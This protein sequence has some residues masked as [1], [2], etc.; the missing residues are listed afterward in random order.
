[1]SHFNQQEAAK[2]KNEGSTTVERNGI[3]VVEEE[4]GT[5]TKMLRYRESCPGS[6]NPIGI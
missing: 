2:T 1:V 3:I 4:Q 6:Y 5:S